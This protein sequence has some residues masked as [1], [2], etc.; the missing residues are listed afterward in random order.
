MNNSPLVSVIINCHNGKKYLH[1]AIKSVLNQTYQNWE[2]IFF[3]NNSSDNSF[4]IVKK[5]KKKKI[6][7]F[8]YRG[9]TLPLYKA[10]NLAIKKAKGKF[11]TFLDTDDKWKKNKLMTQVNFSK[12]FLKEDIFYSNYD[13]IDEIKN[14]KF[15]KHKKLPSG[16]I[17]KYLA[18]NYV[19]SIATLFI[20]KK[21][22]QKFKFNE[23][24]NLIGDFDFIMRL[25]KV[26]KLIAIQDSLAYYRVHNANFSKKNT[27]IYIKELKNWVK[28]NNKKF[29]TKRIVFFIF[30]LNIKLFLNLFIKSN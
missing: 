27:D 9:I 22:F 16:Y 7:S 4:E 26:K 2:I 14:K 10:R 24:Y 1:E 13:V 5:Y 25:S 19:V 23:T 28:K 17:S 18:Q 3:D 11:I 21:I 6:K 29:D 20:K 30:K 15:I 12:K 8:L